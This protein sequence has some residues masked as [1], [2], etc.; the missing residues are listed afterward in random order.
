MGEALH[1]WRQYGLFAGFRIN[2]LEVSARRAQQAVAEI[3][4]FQIHYLT[5][6]SI[7]TSK[8]LSSR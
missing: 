6:F 1:P 3:A 2:N 4:T 7:A 5:D 8:V